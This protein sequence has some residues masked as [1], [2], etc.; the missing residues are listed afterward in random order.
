[1]QQELGDAAMT[2]YVEPDLF[3]TEVGQADAQ[4][5]IAVRSRVGGGPGVFWLSGFN[6]DM[7]GTK[8]QAL[9][10]WAARRGRACVRFD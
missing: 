7:R 5:R 4:R 2:D 8:A 1:M 10:A 6:S 3:F 9:D